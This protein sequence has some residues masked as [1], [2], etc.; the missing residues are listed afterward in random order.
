MKKEK[1]VSLLLRLGLAFAFIYAAISAFINPTAW[2]GF[3]PEFLRGEGV[4]MIFSVGEI[5]LGL[6]LLWGKKV[7]YAAILS[8]LAM[9]GIVWFN[10]GAMDIVFRDVSI[11]LMAIALAVLSRGK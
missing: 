1:L 10:F 8:A 5:V 7:F 9:A 11:L 3:F 6:W 2:I 4:L